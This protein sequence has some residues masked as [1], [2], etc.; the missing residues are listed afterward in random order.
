MALAVHAYL[1]YPFLLW[2]LTA[3]RT[4]VAEQPFDPS[5]WP[6]VTM[7]I[8]AFNESSVIREKLE[9]CVLLDY[10]QDRMEIIVGSDGSTDG[11]DD[12]VTSF[13][14]APVRLVPLS[15][16]RGKFAVVNRCVAEATGD[17]VVF[18]DA[19]TMYQPDAV[20]R[21]VREFRE[22]SVGC[23]S[24]LLKLENRTGDAGGQGEGAYWRFESWIKRM[25]SRAGF[26]IGAN[27]A[28]YAIR[29]RLFTPLPDGLVNDDFFI[30]MK[31]LEQGFRVQLAAD[32]IGVEE[33][34]PSLEGE[35][36]RHV[37]DA[38][39]HFQ[40]VPHLWRLLSPGRGLV[41]FGFF[42]HRIA[43]W[44]VPFVLP[45]ALVLALLNLHAPI[46]QLVV[47]GFAV[48]F[49][50]AALGWVARKFGWRIGPLV[51]PLYFITLNAA[52]LAGFVRYLRRDL[53]WAKVR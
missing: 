30:S 10:P 1:G 39:G 15:G 21:L 48:V 35:F 42:S 40:V 19:N 18:S 41:A 3:L 13:V 28:I 38:T 5:S 46:N 50:L 31:V 22:P 53:T 32:A 8:P 24:G 34:A 7:V 6:T 11:T 45:V 25:E 47:G 49:G 43:R 20:R 51:A 52:I 29:R 37:R 33:T 27:G 17:I 2:L 12:I 44:A 26:L 14:G 16:H 4:S 36:T 23:V 9:N